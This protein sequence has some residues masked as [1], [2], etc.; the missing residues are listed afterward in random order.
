MDLYK[1]M[2][3]EGLDNPVF[4]KDNST[5]KEQEKDPEVFISRVRCSTF[6]MHT[7]LSIVML[8]VFGTFSRHRSFLF[9][10]RIVL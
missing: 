10:H 8:Q 7:E 1:V 5:R 4:L 3:D 6:F 9:T 2:T